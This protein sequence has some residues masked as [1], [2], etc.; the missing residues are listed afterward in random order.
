MNDK[1]LWLGVMIAFRRK[2]VSRRIGSLPSTVFLPIASA[3]A[4]PRR[5]TSVTSPG[6]SPRST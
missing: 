6:N 1:P 3:C 2:I 5:L 4:S